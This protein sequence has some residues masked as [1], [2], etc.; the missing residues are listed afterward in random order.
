MQKDRDTLLQ[1]WYI[2]IP[3]FFG[4]MLFFVILLAMLYRVETLQK[5]NLNFLG[6]NNETNA[7]DALQFL[8]VQI[9][10]FQLYLVLFTLIAG[11]VA[12]L[13]YNTM[14]DAV[15]AQL[16]EPAEQTLKDLLGEDEWKKKMKE[17]LL[18]SDEF[19]QTIQDKVN[20]IINRRDY[21]NEEKTAEQ[22]V[23]Q[24]VIDK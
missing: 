9:E 6:K 2:A 19:Q 13:G 1:K 16:K 4:I 17:E 18:K 8:S 21:K 7:G 14:R 20:S 24:A 5:T 22:A 12:F 23:E 11:V 10:T 15:V 3:S